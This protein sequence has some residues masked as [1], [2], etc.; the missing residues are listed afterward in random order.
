MT[1]SIDHIELSINATDE[2]PDSTQLEKNQEYKATTAL[3]TNLEQ[4]NSTEEFIVYDD[5]ENKKSPEENTLAIQALPSLIISVIGLVLAGN[6]M[7]ELQHSEVFLKTTELFILLPILLNLK[8]NLEMNLAARFSTSSNLG[9]LDYGPTRRSLIVGNLAL[10]QV[11]SLVSGAIAGVSSFALGLVTKPGSN[12]SYYEM[13]YMTSSS[14]VSAS[15][16]SAILGIFMCA[17]ILICRKFDV[18]PDNIACPM[19]SSIGDIVTL[20]LLASTASI[21]QNQM[22]S[23]FSTLVFLVMFSLIPVFG[24]IVWKNKHVKK[25]LFSG[26]TPLIVAMVISS[27]A[28]I[29]LEA[30]V[31]QFK[32]VALLTP[33]L[34][35]LAGNLGSIYASRISTCLHAETKESYK[36]VELTLLAMNVPVQ[37]VFMIIIWAFA[38]GQLQYNFW[39]FFSYF[40]I[41][42]ICTWICL[43]IGKVMT[44]AFW[45][46]GYDPDNYVIPYLTASIDVIGTILLVSVFSVLT[47]TGATDMSMTARATNSTI[48]S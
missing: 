24:L 8:G 23:I 19:A 22:E 39:F 34:I 4:N 26:W 16:S 45:K 36:V 46:M 12:N 1:N 38:M 30:Y 31:E 42:M 47:S 35:G 29:L 14:M 27:L 33:V 2:P 37:V 21:L 6:L 10:L 9:E 44:L 3:L 43:K 17:L 20:V 15:F 18:D 11:Q 5:N 7:D 40:V 41:S 13:I 28:G 25:L 48:N 32:G